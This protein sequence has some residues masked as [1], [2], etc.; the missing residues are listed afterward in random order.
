LEIILEILILG[1]GAIGGSVAADFLMAGVPI[2]IT[3]SWP[4]VITK[5]QTE[6]LQISFPDKEFQTPTNQALHLS[7]LA[8]LNPRFDVVFLA[9]KAQDAKWLSEFIKPY[10]KQDGIMVPLMN[11]M[12]NEAIAN[13]IGK[14]RLIGSVI[15]LSAES[16][17]PGIIKRKTPPSKTW[18]AIGEFNGQITN[19]LK[20]VQDLLSHSAKV[21][22]SDQIENAKWTKLVTN[23]MILAPFA[24]IKAGSY[25]A[26]SD[27]KMRQLVLQIGQEAISVGRALGYEIEKIFGLTAEDLAGEPLEISQKL[28]DTLVGHIG[29]KSQNATTQDVIKGRLTET[30]FINGLIVEQGQKHNISVMANQAICQIIDQIETHTLEATPSNIALA[31]QLAKIN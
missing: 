14:E 8:R 28:V 26:F 22:F 10:L 13:I 12:M 9:A 3:D 21:D 15:E 2:S 24:M 27:P 18:I 1:C 19:R 30:R 17:E 7:D 25:D 20:M 4:K 5:L 29:K 6:G 11:G 31:C 23:A 16:F